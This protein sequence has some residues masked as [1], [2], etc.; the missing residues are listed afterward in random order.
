METGS[1][2]E[3]GSLTGLF[4]VNS[5]IWVIKFLSDIR[6]INHIKMQKYNFEIF[7]IYFIK[8]NLLCKDIHL[9]CKFRFLAE[10]MKFF[11]MKHMIHLLC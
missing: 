3:N 11:L 9:Y 6:I 5:L 1:G 8:Q 4:M 10:P 2:T 7:L